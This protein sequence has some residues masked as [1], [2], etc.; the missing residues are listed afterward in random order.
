[1]ADASLEIAEEILGYAEEELRRSIKTGD[2][3]LYRNAVDRAFLSLIV[4]VNSY[5]N[6]R[7]GLTPKSHSERRS[8]LRKMDKEDLRAIYS[9]VMRT[10]HEEAFYMGVYNPE[11]VEY[12]IKQIKKISRARYCFF[13]FR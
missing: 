6:G 1:M 8:L 11:E 13:F 4:A 7:L 10:L 9:D 5:I 3:L 12:P 2:M